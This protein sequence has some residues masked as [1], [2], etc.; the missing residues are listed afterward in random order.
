MTSCSEA[1]PDLQK[2]VTCSIC[3]DFFTNPVSIECGHSFC[4]SCLLRSYQESS[5]LSS[6]PE[7]RSI[8]QQREYK[9]N[10]QLGRLTDIVK[11]LRL[12][13][14]NYPEGHGKCEVHQKVKKLFC[15]DDLS[16]ICVFCS[17]SQEHETHDLCC[18]DEAAE[19]F[20]GKLQETVT[21]LWKKSE[22]TVRMMKNEKIKFSQNVKSVL[23]KNEFVLQK[24]IESVSIYIPM[25]SIPGVMERILNLEVDITLDC[26]TADPGLIISEDLKSV[27]YGGI[28]E[29]IP[30]DSGRP[31]EFAQVL[32]TQSFNSG[33]YYWEVEVPNNTAW[34]VG[35][36]NKSKDF[37]D[38][39]VLSN[40]Q[41]N[42]SYYLYAEAQHNLYFHAQYCQA[43]VLGLKVGIF[44]DY[45]CG[46][47]SFYHVKNRHLIY[48]FPNTSFSGHL[49]PLFCLSKT[50]DCS[51][52]ICA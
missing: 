37:Q 38:F 11:K 21:S 23:D 43:S 13:D 25:Q 29:E 45:E 35:I 33:R 2:E 5:T 44:L 26:N 34:R 7:C 48:T 16:P 52:T 8:F 6:C 20:R 28:Q 36:C 3:Y 30:N 39:F 41:V 32:G 18:I 10:L 15:E 50:K 12:L 14:L 1:I 24:N 47:I 40:R 27:R 46:E 31:I 42:N 17:Q 49:I 51:L 22:D 4:Q 9:A 19:N